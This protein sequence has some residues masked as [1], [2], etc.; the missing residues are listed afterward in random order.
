MA[1]II[2][3]LSV[4]LALYLA[5]AIILVSI[6][7]G[8]IY[9]LALSAVFT[10]AGSLLYSKF[11]SSRL[12]RERVSSQNLFK[13]F[14]VQGNAFAAEH[15]AK[16]F[17]KEFNPV[18]L[19]DKILLDSTD[20][21]RAMVFPVF[22]YSKISK[23]EFVKMCRTARLHNAKKIYIIAGS[24][25]REIYLISNDFNVET[26]YIKIHALYKHL[27]NCDALPIVPVQ[28]KKIKKD[29]AAVKLIF[30]S[31]F[32]ASNA[33]RFLFASIILF[34][35]SVITPLKT[36]YHITAS[37]SLGIA[38]LCLFMQNKSY[39]KT[40]VFSVKKRKNK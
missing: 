13:Y 2:D 29:K 20:D 14:I 8:I 18:I 27:K 34:L 35:M 19:E 6:G 40:P 28:N 17:D 30:E 26:I 38:A 9:A 21:E 25:E 15:V 5:S 36:Y 24:L 32:S 7:V 39:A 1:K 4:R 3:F 31:L 16:T 11:I 10:I 23:D 37:I 33:R 22:K 12:K